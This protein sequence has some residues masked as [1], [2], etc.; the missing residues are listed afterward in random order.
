M[1]KKRRLIIFSLL[2]VFVLIN[3]AY[4]AAKDRFFHR[5]AAQRME[6]Y[7]ERG[8]GLRLS[9][10]ETGGSLF[11][12]LRFYNVKIEDVKGFPKG[13]IVSIKEA[14]FRY[15]LK[16]LL[17]RSPG[18]ELKGVEASCNE[19]RF[20]LEFRRQASRITLRLEE[21]MF[22]LDRIWRIFPDADPDLRLEGTIRLKAEMDLEDFKLKTFTAE[23]M[24]DGAKISYGSKM[25]AVLLLRLDLSGKGDSARLSGN[26]SL[27]E[28]RYYG[29]ITG[30]RPGQLSLP[31][32]YPGL[33]MDISVKGN[34]IW[35]G[36]EYLNALVKANL[37][38][39]KEARKK[40]YLLGKF[41]AIKGTY[42]VLENKFKLSS[43]EVLFVGPFGREMRIDVSG[44]AK[45]RRYWISALVKG[46]PYNSRLELISD[47]PL[48]RNEI[49]SLLLFG[50]RIEGLSLEQEK[51]LF[52]AGDVTA[53]FVN[54][55]FLGKAEAKI[56]EAI[57]LDDLNL[58]A[59]F[60]KEDGAR[61]F[62]MPSVEVGKYLGTDRVYGTYKI[63]PAE[64]PG[65]KPRQT[66][67]GEYSLT[68][69]LTVRGERS[70]QESMGLPS[71]DKVSVE[72]KWKF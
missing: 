71:E 30:F 26:I 20:P 3:M 5:L 62:Q 27:E 34:Y 52:K 67:S 53:A 47:P 36:N 33:V 69:N 32:L 35:I 7:F 21:K 61:G 4:I 6:S 55:F 29:P 60:R 25:E 41:E 51:E 72:F 45:V 68:D 1:F 70:F 18:I 65:E 54:K 50:K 17:N 48:N 43:G 46:T 12:D 37:K 8:Y 15:G 58:E 28:A 42:T 10:G 40:P 44:R 31:A 14:V 23:V 63:S 64:I 22:E 38:L 11:R 24:S 66:M 49:F 59:D 57:G 9:I 39:L 16:D 19:L 2:A 13:L 56:A